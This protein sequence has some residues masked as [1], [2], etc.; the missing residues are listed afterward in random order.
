MITVG[1][2]GALINGDKVAMLNCQT[3][4]GRII[5][6]SSNIRMAGRRRPTEIYRGREYNGNYIRERCVC[7]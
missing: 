1:L 2:I 3:P 5:I 6:M 7:M 4:V